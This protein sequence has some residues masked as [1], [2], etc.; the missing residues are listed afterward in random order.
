MMLT[1]MWYRQQFLIVFGEWI[2]VKHKH[3]STYTFLLL[4]TRYGLTKRFA[5]DEAY[6][7]YFTLTVIII[8]VTDMAGRLMSCASF[9]LDKFLSPNLRKEKKNRT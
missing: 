3:R 9:K 8:I 6:G 7:L 2:K 5:I 4:L 1:S